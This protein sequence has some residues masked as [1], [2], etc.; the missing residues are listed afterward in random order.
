[1][2]DYRYVSALEAARGLEV[3]PSRVRALASREQLDARKVAGRWLIKAEALGARRDAPPSHGRPF[4]PHNAFALLFLASNENVSWVRPD[5]RSRLR[6]VARSLS[7]ELPRLRQR[8]STRHYLASPAALAKLRAD[9][10]FVRSGV[11]AAED[12]G[13]DIISPNVVEG[14]YLEAKLASFAYRFALE[15]LPA[16]Q[17]N[18]IVHAVALYPFPPRAVMPPAVV[19]VDLLESFDERS[20]R[21]GKRLLRRL[22]R[23]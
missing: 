17:A 8:A 22:R 11:S 2:Q 1:M 3:H 15:E 14:Y 10:D 7:A 13:L 6:R 9:P 23:Q 18:L 12:Y 20:R 16:A 19:A 4:A 21:S 5:V